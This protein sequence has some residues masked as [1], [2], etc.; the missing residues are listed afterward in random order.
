MSDSKKIPS[1]AGVTLAPPPSLEEKHLR[2]HGTN[3]ADFG[4]L[5]AFVPHAAEYQCPDPH[6]PALVLVPGLGMDGLGF[7]RQ[8]SLGPHAHL[9]FFQMPNNPIAGEAGLLAFGRYVEEYILAHKLEQHPGGVILGGCSM[10]GAISL[11]IA[12]RGRVKLRGLVLLGTFGSCQ[13][14]PRWQRIAAPLAWIMP[15]R[16]GRKVFWHIT[17]RSRMF[18][19]I[20]PDEASWLVSCKIERSQRYFAHAVKHLT[21]QEQIAAAK[22]LSLPT[23]VLHGTDDR[24]LP[25]AA[26]VELAEAIPGAHFVTVKDA[27]HAVFFTDH[28]TTNQAIA[29]FIQKLPK[30]SV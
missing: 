10:G 13:H 5:E 27:G 4:P 15:L 2:I 7:L 23:L 18:G 22:S 11:A 28:E 16:I 29:A 12:L 19:Q 14:L 21:T 6:A 1:P 20:S 26:G 24:V 30:P 17:S 25:H 3:S 8:L 9:H